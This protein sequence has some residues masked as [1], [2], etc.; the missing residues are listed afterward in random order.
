MRKGRTSHLTYFTE[1][2]GSESFFSSEIREYRRREN[3]SDPFRLTN[4]RKYVRI[5]L[6]T[7]E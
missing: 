5:K 4:R 2:T 1:K 7:N 6:N 3:K